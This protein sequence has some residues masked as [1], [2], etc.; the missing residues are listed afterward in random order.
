M[1]LLG[2][3]GEH[4]EGAR[5]LSLTQPYQG[6]I[7]GDEVYDERRPIEEH[8][9]VEEGEGHDDGSVPGEREAMRM[10]RSMKRMS[11]WTMG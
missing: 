9:G 11:T 3:M 1:D 8:I 6:D 7:E 2:C 4:R 10:G 5:S